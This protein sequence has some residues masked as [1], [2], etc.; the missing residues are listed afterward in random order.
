[1][2]G[3]PP[4]TGGAPTCGPAGM[5][6]TGG[7]PTCGPAGMPDTGGAPTCG[8][9]GIPDT[10]GAPTCGPAGIPDTGGAPTCGPAGIPGTCGTPT[11]GPAGMPGMCGAPTCGPAGMPGSVPEGVGV[12]STPKGTGTIVWLCERVISLIQK[13]H[14]GQA[15]AS[16]GRGAAHCGQ[17]RNEARSSCDILISLASGHHYPAP[18]SCSLNCCKLNIVAMEQPVNKHQRRVAPSTIA[19]DAAQILRARSGDAPVP[20][21]TRRG[22]SGRLPEARP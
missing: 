22:L 2:A 4:D 13:P 11:C 3:M 9:A 15:F 8:P 7:A 20:P 10:G 6:D 16:S 19:R 12:C 14:C 1:V 21:A 18:S 5:P 17:K